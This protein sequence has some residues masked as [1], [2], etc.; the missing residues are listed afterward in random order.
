MVDRTL[1]QM[2][3]DPMLVRARRIFVLAKAMRET[4]HGIYPEPTLDGWSFRV[5]SHIIAVSPRA[6]SE[7]YDDWRERT[8]RS[9]R[10]RVQPCRG[11]R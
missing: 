5:E 7:F 1:S 4:G 8:F 3:V 9:M 10:R 11:A 6:F 2:E